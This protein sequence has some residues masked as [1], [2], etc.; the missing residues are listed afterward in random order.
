MQNLLRLKEFIFL[1]HV[2]VI[3]HQVVL[4]LRLVLTQELLY[5]LVQHPTTFRLVKELLCVHFLSE[6]TSYK[7]HELLLVLR[8]SHYLLHTELKH[9]CTELVE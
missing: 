3:I 5:D 4:I 9:F 1:K 8:V 2:K 6:L 7:N